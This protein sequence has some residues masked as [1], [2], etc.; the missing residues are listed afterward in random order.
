MARL[1][2]PLVPAV[3]VG[4]RAV[5]GWNPEAYAK[6]VGVA[7]RPAS[8]LSPAVLAER[9]DR[10]LA[11]TVR[12]VERMPG[13]VL[14][15]TPS[16]RER[17]VRELAF[18]VF[19]LSLAFI[20]GMDRGDFPQRWLEARV[21]PEI[22]DA[23][24]L[25]AYGARVRERLARWFAGAAPEVYG[26]VV[27]VYYGPQSG[28]DLLERTT[29]H[30]AQHLRQLYVLAERRGVTPPEPLPVDAFEGLPLPESLW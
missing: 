2:I 16:E 25:A 30:A 27:Q 29:W 14:A 5:H 8:K 3:A 21:P 13:P 10:V 6:L 7:Y 24:A 17:T 22:G 15:W 18:H 4:A 11:S 20:E 9:I 1:G 28:H 12:L 26:H 19:R 23:A